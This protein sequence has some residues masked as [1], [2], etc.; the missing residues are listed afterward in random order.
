MR[1]WTL[2]PRYLDS[3]GL[4]ALW[5]E[6]LLAKA[7][8]RGRTA[9]YRHHPQLE[10]FRE[11]SDPVAAINAYLAGVHAEARRRGYQFDAAKLRG[12]RT[13]TPLP[14]TRGQLD[15]EWSHL[16]RKLEQRSPVH[17]RAVRG[18]TRPRAHPQF[19]VKKGPIAP[20]ERLRESGASE[21]RKVR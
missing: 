21:G 15:F 14:G 7:V 19:R 12:R 5:R 16:L 4:I 9:G 6:A 10:R 8:L 17:F 18:L 20:W 11:A 3:I 1:L 13:S 2:H